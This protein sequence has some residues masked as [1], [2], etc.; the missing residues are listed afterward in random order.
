M[1]KRFI[2]VLALTTLGS[3]T[4]SAQ[5]VPLEN[6]SFNVTVTLNT[7]CKVAT[8]GNVA[9]SAI[10][11]NAFQA[12]AATGVAATITYDC[13][14]GLAPKVA[15]D[16]ATDGSKSSGAAN[17]TTVAG[18]GVVAG[19]RYELSTTA[20]V[21]EAGVDP[22]A[23]ANNV[24]DAQKRVYA[25]NVSIPAGQAGAGSAQQLASQVQARTL[26]LSY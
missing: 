18:G 10:T 9:G 16:T 17:A 4:A 6:A 26:M 8:N 7:S 13:T 21:A 11:Y 25:I 24:N 1:I 22:T 20:S 3:G 19:L 23:T 14:R 15:F 2:P 12:G 5:F